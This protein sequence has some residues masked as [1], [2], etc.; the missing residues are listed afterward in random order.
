MAA[1]GEPIEIAGLRIE[2]FPVPGK[3]PLYREG[4][5]PLLGSEAGETAGVL[6]GR[7]AG[8]LAYVPGCAH[9]SPALLEKLREA[10]ILLFD[11]TLFT[12]DEMI[13]AGVGG[14]TGWRMGHL[15]ISGH[16][17]SL[18]ALAGLPA[19]RKLFVH[20]NNT[21]RILVEGSPERR[22]VEE[23]GF[24]LARDGMELPL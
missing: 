6:I 10:D 8:K 18:Q 4:G 1:A 23:A 16:G 3:A 5:H 21:N 2:I 20:I 15:P 24:E 17:G 14:K 7:G 11:G 22:A 13:A 12:D 19:R 9:L